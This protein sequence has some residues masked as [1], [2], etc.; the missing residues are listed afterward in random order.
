ME[1]S[2]FA[3]IRIRLIAETFRVDRNRMYPV[4]YDVNYRGRG[5]ASGCLVRGSFDGTSVFWGAES[6]RRFSME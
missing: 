3:N 6:N 4:I 5:V 2:D 1:S